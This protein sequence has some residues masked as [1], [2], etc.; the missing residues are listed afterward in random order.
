MG[1]TGCWMWYYSPV[2]VAEDGEEP[3]GGGGEQ[4]ALDGLHSF[5]LVWIG[6]FCNIFKICFCF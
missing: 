6:R 4:R 5:S 1:N 3:G 2:S